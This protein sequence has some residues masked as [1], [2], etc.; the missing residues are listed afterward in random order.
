METIVV[1][2]D[3]SEAAGR[4]LERAAAVAKAFGAKLVVTSVAP[5]VASGPRGGGPVPWD[6]PEEHREQL[7]RAA[8]SLA[9]QGVDA[10]LIPAMGDPAQAILEIAEE[11]SADMIVVGTREIGVVGRF[12]GDSVS[13]AVSR[14]AHCDVMIVH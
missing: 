13:G 6:T 3:E 4:A 7:E 9:E 12:L 5:L 10:E 8:A 14:K 11:R 1:G 2:F